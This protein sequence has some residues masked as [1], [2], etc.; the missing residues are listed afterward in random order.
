L[1][2]QQPFVAE[3]RQC[4]FMVGIELRRSATESF[5]AAQMTG[6]KVCVAARA[7]GLLTRPIRDTI[8]LMPPYCVTEAQLRTA[9]NALASGIQEVCAG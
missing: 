8:V 5:P 2:A 9:V 3:V 1:R 6:A 4:G 7:P